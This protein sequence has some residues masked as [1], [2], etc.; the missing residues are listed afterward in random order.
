[1]IERACGHFGRSRGRLPPLRQ[2]L[3]QLA[4]RRGGN[5]GQ[6]AGEVALGVQAVAF[7]AGDEAVERGGSLGGDIMA[8]KQPV[9][10]VM[11][12]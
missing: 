5:A 12:S 3:L 9:L 4:G 2:E 11:R 6:D 8:G 1:M 10:P 7:G